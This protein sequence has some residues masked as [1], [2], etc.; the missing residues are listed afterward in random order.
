MF[1]VKYIQCPSPNNV[2]V[3]VLQTFQSPQIIKW[4]KILYLKPQNIQFILFIIVTI[5]L[6]VFHIW[7]FV[8]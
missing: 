8:V 4:E 7:Q 2:E 5:D 6:F 3:L 1:L